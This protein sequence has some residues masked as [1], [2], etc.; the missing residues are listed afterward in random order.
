MGA[1]STNPGE[2]STARISARSAALSLFCGTTGMWS[3]GGAGFR[4]AVVLET[5]VNDAAFRVGIFSSNIER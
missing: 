2:F 1:R 4:F 5:P 3:R